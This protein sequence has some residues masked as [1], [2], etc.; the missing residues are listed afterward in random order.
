[1]TLK[2][3]KIPFA[4]LMLLSMA[5]AGCLGKSDDDGGGGGTTTVACVDAN[6][7]CYEYSGVGSFSCTDGLFPEGNSCSS[8]VATSVVRCTAS[9]LGAT[10]RIY[11]SQN[12]VGTL[13]A[14]EGGCAA[15]MTL[16]Q[17]TCE[18]E[19]GGYEVLAPDYNCGADDT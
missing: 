3:S 12:F 16:I 15:A 2:S 14:M 18:D 13:S 10:T 1:M 7:N 11:Y 6:H 19:G 9:S 8:R 17:T 5:A 4:T